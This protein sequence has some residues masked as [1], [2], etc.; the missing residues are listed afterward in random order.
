[1]TRQLGK[2]GFATC[3]EIKIKNHSEKYAMK[4]IAKKNM[5]V[6]KESFMLKVDHC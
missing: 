1:V 6:S 2:G 4:V 5:N 3:Y